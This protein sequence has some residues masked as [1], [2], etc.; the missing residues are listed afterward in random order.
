MPLL[1]L[2]F[3]EPENPL[4]DTYY[5]GSKISLTPRGTILGSVSLI[6]GSRIIKS[7]GGRFRTSHSLYNSMGVVQYEWAR[8]PFSLSNRLRPFQRRM[9]EMLNSLRDEWCTRY[10]Y[11]IHVE[12]AHK[13]LRALQYH[14]V[15]LRPEWVISQTRE[16]IWVILYLQKVCTSTRDLEVVQ[17]LNF[18]TPKTVDDVRQHFGFLSYYCSDIQDV[19]RIAKPVYEPSQIKPGM[20]PVQPHQPKIKG[21]HLPSKTPCEVD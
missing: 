4:T 15:K 19:P 12:G 9:E 7:Y 5:L 2:S 18:K 10:L 20:S 17:S 21:S 16:T 1:W 3:T 14:G 11:D 6:K 8:I 13:V